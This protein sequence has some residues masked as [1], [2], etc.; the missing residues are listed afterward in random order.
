ME[1]NMKVHGRIIKGMDLAPPIYQMDL[2]LKANGWM[3][4]K[5]VKENIVIQM[6]ISTMEI[7][8]KI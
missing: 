3:I 2:V 7:G 1:I 5:Q 4:R 8:M 6:V